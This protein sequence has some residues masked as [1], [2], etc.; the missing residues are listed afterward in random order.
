MPAEKPLY[1]GFVPGRH[2]IDAYGAGGFRFADMSHKG[3]ILALPSGV[4]AWDAKT[5]ADLTLD[6]FAPVLREADA[7]DLL[8]VGVG[9]DLVPLDEPVLWGLR[10]AGIRV[11]VMQ[12]GAAARTYTILLGENRRVAAALLAGGGGRA[13]SPGRR[14]R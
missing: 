11:D 13:R 6:A 7:F 4:H 2:P 9:A 5:P 8:L 3:S 14:T 1:D 10:D 12:T